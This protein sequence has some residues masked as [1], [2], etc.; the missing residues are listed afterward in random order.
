MIIPK[1]Y[2]LSNEI[3][4]NAKMNIANFSMFLKENNDDSVAL[5]YGACTFINTKSDR[6]PNYFYKAIHAG[7]LTDL[8]NCILLSHMRAELDCHEEDILNLKIGNPQKFILLGKKFI[9][10]DKSFID[11]INKKV[12]TTVLKDEFK[13]LNIDGVKLNNKRYLVWY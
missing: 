4:K 1:H 3:A 5:K 8:S 10:F 9:R 7:P 11:T 13:D 6:L 12:V 2:A